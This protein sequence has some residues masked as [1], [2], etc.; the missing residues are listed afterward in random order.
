[1]LDALDDAEHGGDRG[2]NRLQLQDTQYEQ[3]DEL[4]RQ[5]GDQ[6][7][8]VRGVDAGQRR[9]G[10]LKRVDE[11]VERVDERD[12]R[13]TTMA[14]VSTMRPVSRPRSRRRAR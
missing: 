3:I 5:V 2:H 4:L 13:P 8:H 10:R 14:P 1:M 12:G 7:G 11:R 9:P 6:L